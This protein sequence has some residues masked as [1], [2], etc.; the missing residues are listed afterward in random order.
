VQG[1]GP[2]LRVGGKGATMITQSILSSQPHPRKGRQYFIGLGLGVIPLLL[3][4]VA[5]LDPMGGH[6]LAV[7]LITILQVQL[8]LALLFLLTKRMRPLGYGLL[9]LLPVAVFLLLGA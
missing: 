2:W 9:T 3:W 8:L 6:D 1:R 4:L 7:A 5:A